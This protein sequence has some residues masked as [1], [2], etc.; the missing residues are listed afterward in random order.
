MLIN[1]IRYHQQTTQAQAVRNLSHQPQVV[2]YQSRDPQT[3]QR[4]LKSADGGIV[5]A[6]YLSTNEPDKVPF[7]SPSGAIGVPG[8]ITNR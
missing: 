3:G 2:S 6:N 1:Q 7:Y 8:F 5:T 4:L